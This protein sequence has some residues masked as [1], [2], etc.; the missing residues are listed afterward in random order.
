MVAQDAEQR[1]IEF[2][3]VRR[4]R[5]NSFLFFMMNLTWCIFDFRFGIESQIVRCSR[6]PLE[7]FV[8]RFEFVLIGR[9]TQRI[10]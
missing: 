2:D 3:C 7:F 9:N 1:R 5:G 4:M 8:F 10:H 6:W